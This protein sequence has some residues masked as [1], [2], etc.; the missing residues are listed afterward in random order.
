MKL[1]IN[2]LTVLLF[3]LAIVT[4]C[5]KPF[6]KSQKSILAP[7]SAIVATLGN[8]ISNVLFDPSKVYCYT[9]KGKEK[10]GEKDIEVTSHY[11]RDSLVCKLNSEDIA[12]LQ[13]VLLSDPVNYQVDSVM[14]R[15]PYVPAMEFCFEKKK[16][17][18][19]VLLSFSDYSWTIIADG[20]DYGKWNYADRDIIDRL[21]KFMLNIK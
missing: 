14:V 12:I 11:V 16:L 4:S 8:T 3:A 18:V 19:H 2:F 10:I 7:D 17:Q 9:L 5:A 20:K 1:R 21:R 15:S 6:Q 13:F